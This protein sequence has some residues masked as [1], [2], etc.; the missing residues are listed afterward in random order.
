MTCHE[1]TDAHFEHFLFFEGACFG[2]IDA[3]GNQ[4]QQ[5]KHT[6]YNLV[7]QPV[8]REE[9]HQFYMAKLE[10]CVKILSTISVQAGLEE[11]MTQFLQMAHIPQ[12]VGQSNVMEL[13]VY[14]GAK[15]AGATVVPDLRQ[16]LTAVGPEV[17]STVNM[18]SLENM[19]VHLQ[20]MLTM[21]SK[22]K[23]GTPPYL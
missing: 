15:S 1:I 5:K 11:Y 4:G 14:V 7:Y 2:Q 12:L 23:S 6:Y 8:T 18:K 13:L 21:F 9:K 10:S 20:T 22:N 16:A 3:T 17:A 19:H